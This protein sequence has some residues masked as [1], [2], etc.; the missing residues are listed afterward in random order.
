M[1]DVND[2]FVIDMENHNLT[3]PNPSG[4]AIVGGQLVQAAPE[5]LQ[6]NVAAPFLNSLMTPGNPNAAQTSWASDYTNVL[7]QANANL[8]AALQNHIH[9]SEPNY[10]WQEGLS[11]FGVLADNSVTQTGPS[12]GNAP[13]LSG[14]LQAKGIPWK[15]YQ[16]DTD[17]LTTG[18]K[19][20]TAGNGITNG[21]INGNGSN[22]TSTVAPQ[23]QWTVPLVNLSGAS[24]SYV[25]PY[26]GSN[27]YNF[28]TKH[29][30]QLFFNATNGTVNGATTTNAAGTGTQDAANPESQHYAPLQQLTTD[31]NN[32]TVGRYNLITPDQFN[33]MHTALNGGFTY[34]GVHY[35]GD[36]AAVAQGDNFLSIIIPQI[37]AS[38][39]Y[40][41]DGAIV[42]WFD[43]TEPTATTDAQG[44]PIANAVAT[45]PD[46]PGTTLAEIVISPLAVGNGFDVTEPLNHT[47]DVESLE[48]IFG[49][50]GSIPLDPRDTVPV[51]GLDAFFVP[52][53]SSLLLLLGGIPA[54]LLASRRGKGPGQ[55]IRL[56]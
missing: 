25:N 18:G 38:Q 24:S 23:S 34:Q 29:D 16:E 51:A 42:I 39:A 32:N 11:N 40:K 53:P 31:L 43:E 41:N 21:Q 10:L 30:G 4:N 8:P 47:S 55:Q 49:L 28:A 35:T 44:N 48:Q 45:N 46:V 1:T 12:V 33:D 15:S 27:Q 36:Q 19:N 52:E 6:G 2:V 20:G 9:P 3:D 7:S 54:L 5:Q 17:L 26:N 13:S 22:L 37:M 14:A 50:G 56:A